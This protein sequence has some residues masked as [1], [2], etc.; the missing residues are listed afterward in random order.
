M[1]LDPRSMTEQVRTEIAGALKARIARVKTS[2][3]AEILGVSVR[4]LEDWRA[5]GK[6]PKYVRIGKMVRYEVGALESYIE[7]E[8]R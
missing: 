3:A 5:K 2:V 4:T 1:N 7:S 6:G 8:R